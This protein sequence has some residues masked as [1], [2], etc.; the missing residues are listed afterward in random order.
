MQ[1]TVKERGL[2][3]GG[4][5]TGV[6]VTLVWLKDE[7]LGSGFEF[8]GNGWLSDIKTL[9]DGRRKLMIKGV[10]K[11]TVAEFAQRMKTWAET[12]GAAV[13]SVAV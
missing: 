1:L 12:M 9:K 10:L 7:Q 4:W 6:T 13:S 8:D 2:T 3:N 11:G 5:N